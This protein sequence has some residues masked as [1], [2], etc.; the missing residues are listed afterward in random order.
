MTRTT[1]G[2]LVAVAAICLAS[3]PAAAEDVDLAGAAYLIF[4]DLQEENTDEHNKG[5]VEGLGPYVAENAAS[6]LMNA[7]V[8]ID[9]VYFSANR[10]DI[11]YLA[12]TGAYGAMVVTDTEGEYVILSY[13]RNPGEQVQ[14]TANGGSGKYYN[15]SGS[16][17]MIL[18]IIHV[19]DAGIAAK[20]TFSGTI[21]ID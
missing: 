3:M 21:T 11:E 8:D 17:G 2:C 13:V 1:M 5:V 20:Y 10:D 9:V 18:E 12:R 16:G 15:A 6:P 19:S 4:E 14:W 7:F